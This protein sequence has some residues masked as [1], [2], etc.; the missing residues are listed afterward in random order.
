MHRRI[1]LVVLKYVDSSLLVEAGIKCYFGNFYFK[2]IVVNC[3][4]VTG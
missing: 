2:L 1:Q 4:S 3:G